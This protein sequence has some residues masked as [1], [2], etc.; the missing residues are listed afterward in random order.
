MSKLVKDI[1]VAPVKTTTLKSNAGYIRELMERKE[2]HSIPIVHVSAENKFEVRGI[3]TATDLRGVTDE[4]TLA[5]DIMTEKVISISPEASIQ[6]AA[7]TMLF[8]D[9]HHLVVVHEDGIV[10]MLSALDFVRMAAEQR[11]D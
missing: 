4:S 9:I 5:E 6:A 1:M 10:G 8:H 11:A 7:K 2:V 3:V